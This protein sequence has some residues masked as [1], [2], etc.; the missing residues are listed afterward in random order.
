MASN[1]DPKTL[2]YGQSHILYDASLIAKPSVDLFNT[3][4]LT[5]HGSIS[6]AGNGRGE[7][8]FVD[9]DQHH[10]VLRH[11]MRGGMVA[12]FSTYHYIGWNLQA[13]R[14]WK[15][16]RLL[17]AMHDKGLAVPRPVAACVK[18]NTSRIGGLYQAWLLI[19]K[20]NGA[21]TLADILA[22]TPAADDI[23]Q[24]VGKCIRRFH[25]ENIFHAD[26]NANNILLDEHNTV[27]LIDFDRGEFR[28]DGNWKQ[29]NLERLLRSLNK[30]QNIHKTFYFT[31][32]NWQTLLQA[33]QENI[34]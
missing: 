20:I 25:N 12:R 32:D 5:Q 16:W 34:S 2:K 23:W 33:Y 10:W 27:F 31:Q 28:Q 11:Y 18:W 9:F 14:A 13:T 4:W 1:A 3:E 29:T 19:E 8:W 6:K 7:A 22:T 30:L 21:K 26:L 24:A 15:E 17:H